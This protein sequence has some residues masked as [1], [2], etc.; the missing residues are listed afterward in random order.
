MKNK[1]FT[2]SVDDKE[3]KLMAVSPSLQDTK[4]ANKIYSQAFS[5]ALKTKSIVRARL[6][7]I[8]KEQGLWDDSKQAQYEELQ[9]KLLES[10]KQ[11]A[12]GGI[13]LNAARQ[14]ALD[15]RKFR[16]ELRELISDR[17]NL[18]NH[19]AEG[20]A[21]NSKFNYLVY[22]CTVYADNPSKKFF[23]SYENYMQ[24]SSE[25]VALKAAQAVANFIYGL[26]EDYDSKLPENKF[27][28]DYK[29]VDDGLRLINKDGKLVDLEGKL[30]DENGRYINEE[31]QY[32][33]KNGNLVD[34]NGNYIVEFSPF[35]DD[36]G[37]PVVIENKKIEESTQDSESDE[38]P[39]SKEESETDNT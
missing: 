1:T 20:Q 32:V 39:D 23:S 12:K 22:A 34:D 26:D 10:E 17:T 21:D 29:F 18:D 11:L 35:L 27:L 16:E 4:E 5:D 28:K 37:N 30:I 14:I 19:T 24:R 38:K 2:V 3:V 33:D 25:L 9:F 36:D 7:D 15:M 31:G 13:S 6:D 8:L